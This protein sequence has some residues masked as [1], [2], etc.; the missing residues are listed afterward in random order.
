MR[1]SCTTKI[2]PEDVSLDCQQLH[3]KNLMWHHVPGRPVLGRQSKQLLGASWLASLYNSGFQC[4][5]TVSPRNKMKEL[6]EHSAVKS[7][8][9]HYKGP[10]FTPQNPQLWFQ[11]R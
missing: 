7:I 1:A 5:V 3:L 9:C 11:K 6:E 10:E 4:S 8:Y 2:K